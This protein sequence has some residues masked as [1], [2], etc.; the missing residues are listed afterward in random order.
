[1]AVSMPSEVPCRLP[2]GKDSDTFDAGAAVVGE[3]E[4]PKRGHASSWPSPISR[5]A[6][7]WRPFRG[8]W[9][10]GRVHVYLGH[11]EQPPV[12]FL[13]RSQGCCVGRGRSVDEGWSGICDLFLQRWLDSSVGCRD[14]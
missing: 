1:M 2:V 9:R 11:D 6:S 4:S 8:D 3:L 5:G 13:S 12:A 7:P 10:T 14:G